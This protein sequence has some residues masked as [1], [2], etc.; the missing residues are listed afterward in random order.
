MGPFKIILVF[1]VMGGF[2]MD[3]TARSGFGLELDSQN[4]PNNPFVANAKGIAENVDLT[5]FIPVRKLVVV[6]ILI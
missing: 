6:R 3:V 1:R 4:D 2:T 5:I